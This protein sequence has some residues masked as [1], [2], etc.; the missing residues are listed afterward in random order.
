MLT[1]C[2]H[3]MYACSSKWNADWIS[4]EDPE[5]MLS[6]E[7]FPVLKYPVNEDMKG[8][9]QLASDAGYQENEDGYYSKCHLCVDIRKYLH[10][11][12]GFRELTPDALY[13][14]LV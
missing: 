4:E 13:S 3:C 12:N 6:Q 14:N 7:E 2:R 1:A 10:A 11:T 8:L 9:L 5:K